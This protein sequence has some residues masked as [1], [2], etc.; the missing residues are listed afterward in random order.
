MLCDVTI[1]LLGSMVGG[2]G[3][4]AS[5]DC[6]SNVEG[7]LGDKEGTGCDDGTEVVFDV[8]GLVA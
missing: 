2:L 1:V 8:A 3:G 4:R 7:W 6:K 5:S